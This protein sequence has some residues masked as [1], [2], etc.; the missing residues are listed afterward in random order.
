[1]EQLLTNLSLERIG[2]L[3]VGIVA[4]VMVSFM[5][6]HICYAIIYISGTISSA[7]KFLRH[8][9]EGEEIDE[10]SPPVEHLGITIPDG[11]APVPTEG[12]KETCAKHSLK[13]GACNC[14]M[15]CLTDSR[16]VKV[17]GHCQALDM[18]DNTY[19]LC[20]GNAAA[21]CP[22]S[23]LL[24]DLYYCK[25]PIGQ[26]IVKN[27]YKDVDDRLLVNHSAGISKAVQ[28]QH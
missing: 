3:I 26:V 17:G 4:L 18:D 16:C 5:V 14:N 12:G 22:Y 23:T 9:R 21:S 24:G 25:C 19:S 27:F 7:F 2:L 6:Y 1:M 28:M 8:Y 11:G 15:T 20:L 10:A 13:V